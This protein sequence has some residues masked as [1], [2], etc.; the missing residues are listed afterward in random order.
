VVFAS[1]SCVNEKL[2][3]INDLSGLS[4]ASPQACSQKMWIS[5]RVV[6]RAFGTADCP[7]FACCGLGEGK[8]YAIKT[9]PD[10]PSASP[11]ACSQKM[12]ISGQGPGTSAGPVMGGTGLHHF[13]ALPRREGKVLKNQGLGWL[14]KALSTSLPP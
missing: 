13:C 8:S 7:F 2:F 9:L 4:S 1:R 14:V 11:Q 12:W 10:L 3:G 5:L 6:Q